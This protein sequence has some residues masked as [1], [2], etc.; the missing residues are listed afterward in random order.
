MKSLVTS[1]NIIQYISESINRFVELFSEMF[2]NYMFDVVLV[3]FI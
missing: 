1:H 2:S 3:I